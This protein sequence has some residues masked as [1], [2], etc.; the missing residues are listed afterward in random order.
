[1]GAILADRPSANE[2]LAPNR[3]D[4][5]RPHTPIPYELADGSWDGAGSPMVGPIDSRFGSVDWNRVEGVHHCRVL[6][7]T[8]WVATD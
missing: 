5:S 4:Y 1:M 7:E 3:M 8:Y 6:V 2:Q